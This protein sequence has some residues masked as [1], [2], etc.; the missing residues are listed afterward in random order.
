[1]ESP[2]I[3]PFSPPWIST[4]F[5]P[6][7]CFGWESSSPRRS[8]SRALKEALSL[9]CRRSLVPPSCSTL[10]KS[11]DSLSLDLKISPMW[12]TFDPISASCWKNA[13][14]SLSFPCSHC[15]PALRGP[16]SYLWLSRLFHSS[17]FH[18]LSFWQWLFEHYCVHLSIFCVLLILETWNLLF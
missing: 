10:K 6:P 1:M 7:R 18:C 3:S 9:R 4:S 13:P 14:H 11:L 17:D 12:E 8:F 15:W 2:S 16:F 5:A